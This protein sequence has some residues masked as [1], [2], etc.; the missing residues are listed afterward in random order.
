M[1]SNMGSN[2]E[3][4]NSP[5]AYLIEYSGHLWLH[6]NA[7]AYT[8]INLAPGLED[9]KVYADSFEHVGQGQAGDAAADYKDLA[10]IVGGI[11]VDWCW[12]VAVVLRLQ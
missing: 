12:L 4:E 8:G 10:R 6:R 2:N 9:D 5:T 7:S 11:H 3:E 1:G